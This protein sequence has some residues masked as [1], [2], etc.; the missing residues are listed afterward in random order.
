M[1]GPNVDVAEL[2]RMWESGIKS[3]EIC[4]IL[5]ITRGALYRLARKYS[6]GRRPVRL[7]GVGRSNVPDPTEE[8]I[9]ARAAAIRAK[10][11]PN[12]RR[13]RVVGRCGRVEIRHFWFDREQYSFSP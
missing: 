3:E 11:T 1:Y 9:L 5:G 6:L 4:E 12:E 7:T 13:A 10:W 8:E 2:T